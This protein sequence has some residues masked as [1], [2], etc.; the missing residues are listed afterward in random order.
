[1]NPKSLNIRTEPTALVTS[2][3]RRVLMTAKLKPTARAILNCIVLK[4][5]TLWNSNVPSL[6]SYGVVSIPPVYW[7]VAQHIVAFA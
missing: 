6:I 7:F 4:S 5:L 2:D 1:V 3:S